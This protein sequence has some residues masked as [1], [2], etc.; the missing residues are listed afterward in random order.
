MAGLCPHP[1]PNP[2]ANPDLSLAHWTGGA[3]RQNSVISCNLITPESSLSTI[4]KNRRA[5][6]SIR[7][8]GDHD[9]DHDGDNDVIVLLIIGCDLLEHI[10]TS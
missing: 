6:R 2:K 4:L 10:N 8:R 9:G 7:I 1:D 3:V 5:L